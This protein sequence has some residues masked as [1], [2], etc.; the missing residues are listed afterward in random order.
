MTPLPLTSRPALLL[1]LAVALALLALAACESGRERR[2]ERDSDAAAPEP[3]KAVP[4][5]QAHGTFFSGAIE[6]E[7]LLNRNGFPSRGKGGSDGG[8]AA[9]DSAGGGSGGGG[10]WH[11]GGAG[12]GHRHAGGSGGS[13]SGAGAG[14]SDA[15]P[16]I[17]AS[18]QPPVGLHL[19]LINHGPSPVTVE[20]TDFNSDLGDFVVEPERI[21]LAPNEPV[22]AEPMISRLGVTS[23]TIPLTVSLQ[24]NNQTEKQVLL[25]QAVKPAAPPS[26]TPTPAP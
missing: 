20:V 4:E 17:R 21:L 23:E 9:A 14:D 24:M 18:N 3:E 22:E 12:G 1:R 11:G 2:A 25:L 15:A 8:S 7:T 5:M 19:R 13:S 10:G 6:V 16:Q 26:P